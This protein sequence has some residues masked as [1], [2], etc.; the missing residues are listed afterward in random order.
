MKTPKINVSDVREVNQGTLFFYLIAFILS[1]FALVGDFGL[2][3]FLPF[4]M[5]VLGDLVSRTFKLKTITLNVFGFSTNLMVAIMGGLLIVL[6]IN[7]VFS[8][9]MSV[10]F[11]MPPVSSA[12][13]TASAAYANIPIYIYTSLFAIAETYLFQGVLLYLALQYTKNP[14]FSVIASS[15][16][17]TGFHLFVYNSSPFVLMFIFFT[18]LVLGVITLASRNILAATMIHTVNNLVAAGLTIARVTAS[19]VLGVV[20]V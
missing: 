10:S 1:L 19:I 17:W 9:M 4:A 18:G 16:M 20:I 8:S 14:F 13:L 3:G 5:I 2:A 12:A 15:G 6:S 11:L 7:F